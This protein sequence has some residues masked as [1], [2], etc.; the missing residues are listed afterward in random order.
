[1]YHYTVDDLKSNG[2]TVCC[3]E[4]L[5]LKPGTTSKV[6]LNYAPW[7]VPIGRLHC[8][9]T[10]ALEM[11][12]TCVV[13]PS[14]PVKTG[15]ENV[16]FDTPVN[17]S[18][19]GDLKTK[20]EDPNAGGLK[21]KLLSLYGPKHGTADVASDG[22][23]EYNPSPGYNGP[24]R[25]FVSATTEEGNSANFEVLIGVGTQLSADMV[26]TPHVY[27][28]AR[29]ANVDYQFFTASF[30]VTV[31]PTADLCEV[32]RLTVM[33]NAIDCECICYNRTDCYDIRLVKC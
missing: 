6:H 24:D 8:L 27:I 3:C 7:A 15:G 13:N 11:M 26:E 19:T 31:A 17:T 1:M 32:W 33:M 10:F 12:E 25:F 23:F 20:I 18:L 2:C 21:F 9:P 22:T 30:A 28:D 14:A 29:S 5:S 16:M 4:P